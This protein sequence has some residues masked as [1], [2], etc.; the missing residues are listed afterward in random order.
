MVPRTK[1]GYGFFE[2]TSAFQKAIRRGDEKTA[3]YFG[4]ELFNSGLEEYVWKRIKIIVS[5]DIG[6]AEPIMP[7]II[8]SLHQNYNIERE[9][10]KSNRPERMF[11]IHAILLMVR[12][13]KSRLVDYKLITTWREHDDVK[14]PIPD[15]AY[16]MHN[17]KGKQ[18]GRGIEHF[19]KEGAHCE[20]FFPQ[21]GE[22]K[23]KEEAFEA[24]KKKPGKLAFETFKKGNRNHQETLFGDDTS[25]E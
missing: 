18:M 24:V 19:Y 13:K 1:N 5:E 16:D 17:Y 9:E 14:V 12:A 4:V 8:N 7:V 10:K 11:L 25:N 2:T 15:Y 20:N 6:L 3:I 21:D 23:A 22:E